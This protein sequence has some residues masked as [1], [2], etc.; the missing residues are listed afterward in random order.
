MAK[1]KGSSPTNP[2]VSRLL[3]RLVTAVDRGTSAAYHARVLARVGVAAGSTAAGMAA[4]GFRGTV[5]GNRMH[6]ELQM[7]SRELAGAFLPA[8]KAVTA[9]LQLFRKWLEKIGPQTQSLIALGGL[10]AGGLGAVGL[11]RRG[12]GGL[13]GGGLAAAGAGAAGA[14]RGLMPPLAF[15]GAGAAAFGLGH[16]AVGIGAG[17]GAAR[18]GLRGAAKL[19]A[20]LA[21]GAIATEAASG[22]Y[23]DELRA[24]GTNKLG[25]AIG[26]IGGGFMDFLSF[27]K[28][29]EE[30]R[31]RRG[32][33]GT[34][35]TPDQ[36]AAFN[37]GEAEKRR[38]VT[39][40]DA[41]F[42]APGTAFERMTNRLALVGAN[43]EESKS[44]PDILTDI[45]N[46]AREALGMNKLPKP[47]MPGN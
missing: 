4:S 34:F 33:G 5:E 38:M 1:S 23:Y 18:G 19:A 40:A 45:K 14:R 11:A 6:L 15:V 36:I 22:G 42:D 12:I 26:A 37:R 27:G 25:S 41:G 8:I 3:S 46:I 7:I 20:P 32:T 35:S 21:V 30:F 31:K 47:E 17:I 10:A 28:Y 9:G 29:G 43:E 24:R 39:I 2:T 16:E 44:V 13:I